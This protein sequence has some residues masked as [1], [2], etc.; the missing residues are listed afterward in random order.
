MTFDVNQVAG[1]FSILNRRIEGNELHY[2]DNAATSQVP[3]CV[4]EA[5]ENHDKTRRANVKRGIHLLSEEAD[6]AYEN[7]RDEAARYLGAGS[8][9]EVVFTSGATAGINL[10]ALSLGQVDPTR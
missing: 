6:E 7:A 9:D 10:V 3:D 5:M 8:P 2:L 1:R 4:I